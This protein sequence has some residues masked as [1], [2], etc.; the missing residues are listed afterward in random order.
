MRASA[1]LQSILGLIASWA[2]LLVGAYLASFHLPDED[3]ADV[4]TRQT[5]R[6]AVLY[7]GIA[8]AAILLRKRDFGRWAWT[9]GCVAFQVHVVTAFD[10]VHAW[11]NSAAVRHVEYVSGFGP[12]LY[13]SYAF[14]ALW[15]GDAAWWWIDRP[16]YESRSVWLDRAVHAF[17]AFM[18]FSS[19]VIYEGGFIRWAG[20]SLF[21]VLAILLGLR[22][23]PGNK[24]RSG[25]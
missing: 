24:V 4:V 22:L 16:A 1:H 21:A 6:V 25:T 14:T 15:I 7:W 17:V 12:G 18:V 23:Y 10:R 9:L 2:V 5:A 13:V 3:P 19:T 11:S 20:V 8:A